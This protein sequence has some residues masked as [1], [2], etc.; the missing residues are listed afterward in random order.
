MY[1]L[2]YNEDIIKKESRTIPFINLDEIHKVMNIPNTK[3]FNK[4]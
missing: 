3:G 4:R 1:I 2:N